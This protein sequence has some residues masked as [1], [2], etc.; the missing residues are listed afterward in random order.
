MQ[1]KRYQEDTLDA[2]RAFLSSARRSDPAL[3]Y[4]AALQDPERARRLG[5]W[6][7]GYRRLDAL[8]DVPY[9]CL[10]VPTGGG[11]TLLAANTIGVAR[12]CWIER[13]YPL[14]LWLAPTDMIRRQT[15]A[16]LSDRRHLYRQS[17]DADF[18]GRVRVFDIE[19]F[20]LL[21]PHDLRDNC[22]IV[23]GT[24]QT[25][26]VSNTA[27]RK[28]YAHNEHLESHFALLPRDLPGYEARP[29]GGPKYSFANLMHALRPLMIVDEAHNAVTGL[30]R[31][32]QA[33]VNPCAIVEFT[34]TPRF[35]SNLLYSVTGWELKEAE[36]IKL[37]IRLTEHRNDWRSAVAAARIERDRLAEKA[38][39]D[40]D[41]IRPIV[42]L[43]AQAANREVTVEAL[44]KHLEENEGLAPQKIKVA[45]GDQRELD[46]VDLFSP[47]CEVE[48]VITV[49][50][51]KEGWDC[52]FAYVLC[53]V[54]SVNSEVSVEQLLGRV[55]RMPYV[56]RRADPDLNR[57][58]AHLSE[59]NFRAAAESIAKSLEKMGFEEQDARQ[60]IE[61]DQYELDADGLFAPRA[62]PPPVFSAP[63]PEASVAALRALKDD[64]VSVEVKDGAAILQVKG[65]LAPE[66]VGEIAAALPE[67]ARAGF[68]EAAASYQAQAHPRLPPAARGE[69]FVV[70]ALMTFVQ[71]A[72]VFAEPE[73]VAA[74]FEWSPRACDAALTPQD[75]LP[76]ETSE[77]FE[78]DIIGARLSL[79]RLS[80]QDLM[81]LNPPVA[82][83]ANVNFATW[84]EARLR[85]PYLK[86]H[87]VRD[88]VLRAL[89]H[90]GGDRALSMS[91]L[92]SDKYRLLEALRGKL[93]RQREEARKD[94]HQLLLLAPEARVTVSH[95]EG[96]RFHARMF[97][98]ARLQPPGRW[99]FQKHFLGPDRVPALDGAPEGEETQCAL[100]LDALDEVEFW[101]RNASQHRDA[102]RLP[103]PTQNFYPD[104]VARLKDGRIFIVEYKGAGY[105]TNDDSRAK[106]AIGEV[107][108]KA[109][110]GLFLMVEKM[111]HGLDMRQQLE[112]KLRL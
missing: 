91:S 26:R 25:L 29:E 110:G 59:P 47:D 45:T 48:Y 22:C 50:A 58:Y 82:G 65:Y 6:A 3:A 106:R 24:I 53:S 98:T 102:F 10:R 49:E 30:T 111:K 1:L 15:L 81:V 78:I 32:M 57:A 107:W 5:A 71:G 9:V 95:D 85:D 60:L 112:A 44:R 41:F 70:P 33:R 94:A 87:D 7:N 100:A 51:L 84:L 63:A 62:E 14:V 31:E 109:G 17:L 23:V 2:L 73:T 104:F 19:D 96:F 89:A 35:N 74:A 42:L 21:R 105:A 56:K 86:A 52:S 67:A 43:Q 80:D 28:V 88:Y 97:E 92:W 27:G 8:P 99:R 83:F 72:F 20:T 4:A 11:K 69:S 40:K 75:Y 108:E 66:L 55:L 46:G 93:A 77:R 54:A 101:V 76:G 39:A 68:H 90:L 12:D 103:L 61:N 18:N 38:R 79:S 36:M 13:D 34:A 37:P 16:A 64:R